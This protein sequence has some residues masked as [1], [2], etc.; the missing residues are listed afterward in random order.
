MEARTR[1]VPAFATAALRITLAGRVSVRSVEG[2]IGEDR[3]AGR[4]GRLLFAYLVT[5]RGHP[6]PRDELADVLWADAPPA[7]WEKALSVLVSKLRATLAGAGELTG[8]RGSYRL[9]LPEATWVDLDA[10]DGA[11]KDAATA[12]VDGRLDDAIAAA[13]EA[14]EIARSPFL[15]GDASVWAEAKRR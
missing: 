4:Q 15:P 7:T 12:L 1:Q 9:D 6:V 11:A 10:A 3:L 14:L 13:N 8:A 2:E 5:R